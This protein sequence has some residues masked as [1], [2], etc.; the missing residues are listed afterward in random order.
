MVRMEYEWDPKKAKINLLKHGIRFVE[1][2]AVF[3]DD[4]AL[5]I[6]DPHPDEDRHIILGL[7]DTAR[8]L[9]IIYTWRNDVIRIISARKASQHEEEQ[10]KKVKP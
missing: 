9:I 2:V 10:Y 6:D 3:Q 5:R 7:D 8:L 1:A 4:N